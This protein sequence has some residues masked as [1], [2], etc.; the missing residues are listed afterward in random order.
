MQNLNLILFVSAEESS[1]MIKYHKICKF[2]QFTVIC[3]KN[4]TIN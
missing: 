2:S 3:I 4:V 1:V